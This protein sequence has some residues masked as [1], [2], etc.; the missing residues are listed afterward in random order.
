[1]EGSGAGAREILSREANDP[2]T[3]LAERLALRDFPDQR[4][5]KYRIIRE[6]ELLAGMHKADPLSREDKAWLSARK[7]FTNKDDEPYRELLVRRQLGKTL[8][9]EQNAQLQARFMHSNPSDVEI[10]QLQAKS[11]V[12]AQQDK[13][14]TSAAE[15]EE[16]I[17]VDAKLSAHRLPHADADTKRLYEQRLL[18]KHGLAPK[19]SDAEQDRL[20]SRLK[21]PDQPERQEL[22]IR[23]RQAARGEGPELTRDESRALMSKHEREHFDQ[24]QWRK[25]MRS[26]RRTH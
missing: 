5:A 1:M 2:A 12:N 6:H 24:A 19:L 14:R 9:P 10:R 25:Q 7:T 21:F 16:A 8:S 26:V 17:K 15:N 11:L 18:A 20:F 23:R 22:E 3:Q 4:D 13:K